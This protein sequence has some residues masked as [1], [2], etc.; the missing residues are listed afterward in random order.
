MKNMLTI[1]SNALCRITGKNVVSGT[2]G[3]RGAGSLF[4]AGFGAM[5]TVSCP[6]AVWLG[7]DLVSE[8]TLLWRR[9]RL[10]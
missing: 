10:G 4:L 1:I 9:G 8:L 6:A 3:K 2:A 5:L 7:A